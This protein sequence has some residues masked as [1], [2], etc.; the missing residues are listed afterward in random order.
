MI[1]RVYIENWAK[2]IPSKADFPELILRLV[3][4]TIPNCQ[5]KID[6]PIGSSTFMGGWD[7]RV[8]SEEG[9]TYIPQGESGWEFGTEAKFQDKANKDFRKRTDAVNPDYNISE[10][11]FVFATPRIWAKKR[12]VG[13]R[14]EERREMEGYYR[15]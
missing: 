5:N 10:M 6:I 11:T 8:S 9:T 15:L 3:H 4:A 2:T 1:D 14:E 12:R 13:R 7:G